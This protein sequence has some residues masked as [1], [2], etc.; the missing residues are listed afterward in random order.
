MLHYI[1]LYYNIVYGIGM[2][3]A[4]CDFGLYD[5]RADMLWNAFFLIFFFLY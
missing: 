1:M 2:G 3:N 5:L 4:H